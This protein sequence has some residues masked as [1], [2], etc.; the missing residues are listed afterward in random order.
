VW[1]RG[2]VLKNLPTADAVG[3]QSLG[4]FAQDCQRRQSQASCLPAGVTLSFLLRNMVRV[5]CE[6]Q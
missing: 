4:Q 3:S 2:N 1:V 6:L 5:C